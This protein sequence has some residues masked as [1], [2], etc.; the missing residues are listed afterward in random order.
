VPKFFDELTFDPTLGDLMQ[1]QEGRKVTILT[2][3]NNS[4]KSAYLKKMADNEQVLYLGP[5][6]FYSF[7]YMNLFHYDEHELVNFRNNM[8]SQRRAQYSNFEGSFYD[9]NRALTRLTDDRRRQ[10]FDVFEELF[11][12]PMSVKPEFENNEF[13]NRYV[14]IDGD[15]LSVT[16]SGTRLFLGVLAALMDERFRVVALDEPELGLS[17]MLQ[18][19][20]APIIIE[21]DRDEQLFP[22]NPHFFITTHSHAFLDKQNPTNNFI[23]S[24]SGNTI[25][26]RRCADK[27]ELIDIQFRML[28][29]DLGNLFLP[30]AIVFVEGET[31]KL[32]LQK[33][34]QLAFPGKKIVVES[35]SSD[36]AGRLNAW[37]SALG[38]LQT[39]PYRGRTFVVADSVMQSGL[40]RVIKR[41]G[42]PGGS[43]VRWDENGIEYLYPT[44]LLS[45]IFGAQI[46]STKELVIEGDRV[47]A[48]GV[49]KTKMDLAMAVVSQITPETQF[50]EEIANKL[51]DPLR[52]AILPDQ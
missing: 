51:V 25:Q 14:D 49:T 11:G 15:S 30:D 19:K 18:T 23:V 13:S 3:Y 5:N 31:D 20:L 1:M 36:I 43:V 45:G 52:K 22:H 9:T 2:G 10:L 4:G 48:H 7:H 29:N 38:D 28:G 21:R 39:G 50:P 35:C 41:L 26:A 8:H 37:S 46:Q 24:R 40:E 34:L 16:S 32:Y 33:V 42:I 17:P 47:S 6:R 27:Q 12:L 44:N